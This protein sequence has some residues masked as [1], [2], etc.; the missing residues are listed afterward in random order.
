MRFSTIMALVASV[1]A[2][3]GTA[4]TLA[5][6]YGVLEP[7]N[8]SVLSNWLMIQFVMVVALMIAAAVSKGEGK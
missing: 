2:V 5:W 7:K 3:L 6:A 8:E 1:N 4:V